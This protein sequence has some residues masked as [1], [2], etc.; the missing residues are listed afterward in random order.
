MVNSRSAARHDYCGGKRYNGASVFVASLA[1]LIVGLPGLK[2]ASAQQY[3]EKPIHIITADPGGGMDFAAR[4]VGQKLTESFGQQVIVD[5]RRGAGGIIATEAAAKAPPDGYTVL[6]TA[7]AFWIAPLLQKTSYDPIRDFDP[8]TL[9]VRAPNILVV[10]PSLPAKTVQ[11]LIAFAK[12]HRGQLNYASGG[13]GSSN[14]LAAELFKAL[15]GVDM[16]RVVYKGSAQGISD[17]MAGHVQ[18]MFPAA[19]AAMPHVKSGKV[20]A[21]GVTTSQPSSLAPGLP[22]VAS[23]GLPNYESAAIYGMLAP[24]RTPPIAVMRLHEAVSR[25]LNQPDTKEK[26]FNSGV[27][28]VGAGPTEFSAYIKADMARMEKVIKA[29]GIRGK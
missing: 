24:T 23:S 19:A 15:A 17:V 11:G 21:L 4:L 27:E 29:A 1:F 9:L 13:E 5:N 14:H 10:H 25:V 20:R 8:I 26:L 3:P 18:V 22:T 16:V 12:A 6:I 2:C 28:T 7:T